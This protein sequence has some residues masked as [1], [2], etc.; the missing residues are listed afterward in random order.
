VDV[1]AVL[2]DVDDD[3]ND[4]DDDDDGVKGVLLLLED[5]DDASIKVVASTPMDTTYVFLMV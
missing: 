5:E 1:D 2:V 4:D 3:V